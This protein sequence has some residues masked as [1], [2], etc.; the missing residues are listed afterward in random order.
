[1]SN[2][3]LV[4]TELTK[5]STTITPL[6]LCH[7]IAKQAEGYT[8]YELACTEIIKSKLIE[9]LSEG[10]ITTAE[11]AAIATWTTYIFGD[12]EKIG[13]TLAVVRANTFKHLAH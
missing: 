10:D 9:V 6:Y 13:L 12:E 7:L 8:N 5:T 3:E 11:K 2:N 1:M 4:K